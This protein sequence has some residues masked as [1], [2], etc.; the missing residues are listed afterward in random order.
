[1]LKKIFILITILF[2]IQK[3]NAQLANTSWSGTF[4]VPDDMPM[5]IEFKTDSLLAILPDNNQVVETD[6][7]KLS[8]DTLFMTKLE[9]E[10]DCDTTGATYK[11]AIKDGKLFVTPINDPCSQRASAWPVD[12]MIKQD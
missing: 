6:K 2:C 5:I 9:G 12:G 4:K 3:I 10:S 7:Y 1:M 8:N 11:I